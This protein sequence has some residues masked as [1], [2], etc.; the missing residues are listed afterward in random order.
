MITVVYFWRIP[1]SAAGFAFLHMALDRRKLRKTKGVTFAKMLGT[2]KGETFTPRDASLERWGFLICIDEKLVEELDESALV[3][4]WRKRSRSEFRVLLDPIASHGKWSGAEPFSFSSSSTKDGNVV[5][6]TRA[7]IKWMQNFRFWKTV[8]A[9]TKSLHQSAG[10]IT[11]FGIV[12][13]PI[14]LQGTFS[15]WESAAAMRDFAYKSAPHTAAI[16]AT[17]RYK[18]YAEELF[19]RFAVREVRGLL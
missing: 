6:I 10:L 12:E 9:V 3:T 11:A 15:L 18:W 2:G 8:P 16:D 7:R 17:S 14:G 13:A 5:A 1:K 19:A 4:G